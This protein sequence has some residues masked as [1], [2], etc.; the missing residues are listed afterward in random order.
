MG[1]WGA[2]WGTAWGTSWD[3][4]A[5]PAAPRVEETFTGGFWYAFERERIEQERRRRKKEEEDAEVERLEAV[6]REIAQLLRA[7]EEKDADRKELE[8]IG[9]L[10]AK[11]AG[12]EPFTDRLAKAIDRANATQSA[13]AYIKLMLEAERQLREE[14]QALLAFLNS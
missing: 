13:D 11:Y 8:R 14:E 9:K 7:Q 3:R 6:E 4:V 10:A 12:S 5:A 2:S 1:A